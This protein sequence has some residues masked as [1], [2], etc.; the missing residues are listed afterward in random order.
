MQLIFNLFNMESHVEKSVKFCACHFFG[1]L[2]PFV[3]F[4]GQ[5][6]LLP[7]FVLNNSLSKF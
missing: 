6:R 5:I 7:G 4:G 3:D 2:D 1:F